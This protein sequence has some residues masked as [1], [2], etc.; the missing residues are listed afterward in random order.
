MAQARARMGHFAQ[1]AESQGRRTMDEHAGPRR[2][3][4]R[5]TVR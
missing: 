3:E 4:N 5:A 1:C 2:E